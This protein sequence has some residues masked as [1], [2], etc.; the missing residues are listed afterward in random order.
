M[1]DAIS[2]GPAGVS[3]YSSDFQLRPPFR[4]SSTRISCATVNPNLVKAIFRSIAPSFQTV[5]N[6]FRHKQ[7]VV[8]RKP[9]HRLRLT[10][11]P[12]VNNH[13]SPVIGLGNS[14]M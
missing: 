2:L 14:R 7:R 13:V 4:S 9:R 3:A 12:H 6:L 10:P 11:T 5:L 1:S 8:G